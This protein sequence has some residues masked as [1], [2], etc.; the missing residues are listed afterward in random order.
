V[1][2]EV[3][4]ILAMMSGPTL[5]CAA[6]TSPVAWVAASSANSVAL[7]SSAVGDEHHARSEIVDDRFQLAEV[8]RHQ[9]VGHRDRRVGSADGHGRQPEQAVLDIV[10]GQDRDRPL[11]RDIP[12]QQRL[13]DAAHLGERLRVGQC[14]PAAVGVAL[15]YEH[16]IRRG[17]GPVFEAQRQLVGIALQRAR[18]AQMERTVRLF[19][20]DDVGSAESHRP[21]RCGGR[22]RISRSLSHETPRLP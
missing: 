14:A 22:T 12:L 20:E 5:A 11:D 16:T 21:G 10:A 7:R 4:R 6:S 13:R 3:K 19:V 8:G 17:A 18:R 9:R 1:E 15:R 2:P